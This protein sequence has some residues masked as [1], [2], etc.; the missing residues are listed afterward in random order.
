MRTFADLN[1]KPPAKDRR[2]QERMAATASNLGLSLVGLRFT[3]KTPSDEIEYSVKVFRSTG[4][5]VAVGV[6][7]SPTSRKQLFNQL[8]ILRNSFDILAVRS[9]DVKTAVVA[10]RDRRIDLIS[11]EPQ[12]S[13]RAKQSI[14]RT[15]RS[16]V[17]LELSRITRPLNR[18]SYESL[19]SL[20]LE[21][22]LAKRCRIDFTVSSGATSLLTM[23]APRDMASLVAVLGL[24]KELSLRAVSKAPLDMVKRNRERLS[25]RSLGSGVT[26]VRP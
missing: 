20:C 6:D 25:S 18:V 8:R 24:P 12:N 5:D 4:L 15:C 3:P 21:I 11:L 10:A 23:R 2:A 1:V 17:E 13:F 9:A 14:L 26:L 16:A 22:E 19:K 7:L